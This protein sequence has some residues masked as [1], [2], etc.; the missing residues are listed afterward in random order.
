MQIASDAFKNKQTEN[1]NPITDARPACGL[2][3]NE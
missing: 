3:V 1:A 2:L